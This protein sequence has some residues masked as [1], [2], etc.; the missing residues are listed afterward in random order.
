MGR[1]T[2]SSPNSKQMMKELKPSPSR[3]NWRRKHQLKASKL[4][5]QKTNSTSFWKN[6]V[7]NGSRNTLLQKNWTFKPQLNQQSNWQ[8]LRPQ[9]LSQK[10]KKNSPRFSIPSTT[11]SDSDPST[12]K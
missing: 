8:V 12:R 4:K 2:P 6:S 11:L 9:T 1:T 7:R 10:S 5:I 3:K